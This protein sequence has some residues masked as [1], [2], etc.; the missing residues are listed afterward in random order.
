MDKLQLHIVSVGFLC[1]NCYLA[2]KK[3]QA[4]IIDPGANFG[5]IK[6]ALEKNGLTAAAVL[7]THGHFDHHGAAKKFQDA[8]LKIYMHAADEILIARP[9]A[10]R[11]DAFKPDIYVSDGDI[12]QEPGLGIRVITAPGHSMGGVCYY[13][14]GKLFSGDTL[15]LGDVGRTDLYGGDFNALKS[16]IINKLYALPDETE[17]YPG[18]GGA[19]TIGREKKNNSYVRAE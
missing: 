19:T 8:G 17:V 9:P 1:A 2:G 7:L 12:I 16:S 6:A 3:G 11:G 10:K 4:V 14:E 13:T 15:F 18:H 5:K